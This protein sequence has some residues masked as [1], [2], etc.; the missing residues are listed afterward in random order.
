MDLH[1]QA[2]PLIFIESEHINALLNTYPMNRKTFIKTSI[3]LMGASIVPIPWT[4]EEYPVSILLGKGN[5]KL[6]S[7]EIQLLNAVGNAFKRM[8]AAAK[9]DGIL[10]EIVSAYRSFERQKSIW[11]RKFKLNQEEGLSPEQNIN[12]IIEYSTLPGTSRHHWGTDVDLIDGSKIR[13]GDVYS[14]K[15][16]WERTLCCHEKMD[17]K[18][19]S[20][21]WIYSSLHRQKNKK[22]LLLRALALQLC[23]H[24]CP[25]AQKLYGIRFK[26]LT[27]NI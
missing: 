14:L 26:T 18:E 23:P 8:H 7:P 5:P 17:G 13:E 19:C 6:H 2:F 27:L 1:Q 20:N 3:S 11:N 21:L 4:Q 22:R 25:Y 10:L 15:I 12:K 16:S 9:K 24:R